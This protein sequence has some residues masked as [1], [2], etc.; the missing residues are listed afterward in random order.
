[1]RS[2]DRVEQNNSSLSVGSCL[3][4]NTPGCYETRP[5]WSRSGAAEAFWDS[6]PIWRLWSGADWKRTGCFCGVFWCCECWHHVTGVW[7]F[8][9]LR[10]KGWG[11]WR[12]GLLWR[13]EVLNQSREEA[14]CVSVWEE[15]EWVRVMRKCLS[16]VSCS[17]FWFM[18][19]T[20]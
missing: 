16:R 9:R 18:C 10:K 13:Q 11:F 17:L 5:Q 7:I 20:H 15:K 19:Q 4:G 12:E 14:L 1:M 8:M 3:K 6:R 2:N